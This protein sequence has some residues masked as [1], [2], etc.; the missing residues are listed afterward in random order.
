MN[1]KVNKAVY[2]LLELAKIN[3]PF[4]DQLISAHRKRLVRRLLNSKK[5]D[6][7]TAT[8]LLN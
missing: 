5:I 7:Q 1:R 3:S 8:Y 2:E 6:Q 4:S